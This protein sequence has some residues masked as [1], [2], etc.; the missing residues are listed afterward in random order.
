MKQLRGTNAILTG[1]SRGL[2]AY[3]ADA[4]AAEGVNMALAARSAGGLQDTLRA[5]EARG[6]RAIAVACDVT[7]RMDLERLVETAERD[8][9]PIDILINNAG[10]EATGMLTELPIDEI[11]AVLDTNLKACIHL[12]KMVLPAMIGRSGA[13]SQRLIDGGQAGHRVRVDLQRVEARAE[14]VHGCAAL[15]TGRHGRHRQRGVPDVR[16][17]RRD[18]GRRRRREGAA[19]GARGSPEKVAAAVIKA[20]HGTP[21]ALVTFGRSVRCCCCSMWRRGCGRR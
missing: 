6:V 11:D 10:V 17:R 21:E 12:S 15:R 16:Q 2:G 8:L 20:L 18:V 4:L 1:A 13:R 14:R 9:G 19:A 5:V 7:L 3:I